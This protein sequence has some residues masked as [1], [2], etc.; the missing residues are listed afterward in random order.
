MA[1]GPTP[2]L[3]PFSKAITS[4]LLGG[5]GY[6]HGTSIVDSSALTRDEE[7]DDDDA[8][9]FVDDAQIKQRAIAATAPARELLTATPSR[10]FFPRGF[11]WYGLFALCANHFLKYL[12]RDEGF[13]LALVGAWDNDLRQDMLHGLG[14]GNSKLFFAAWRYS[15]LGST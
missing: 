6:F 13:H 8:P 3:L 12:Y 14:R 2:D 4:N 1:S 9:G 10:P 15:S 5:I 11:Y 7:D